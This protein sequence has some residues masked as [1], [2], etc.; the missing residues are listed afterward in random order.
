MRFL[1]LFAGIGGLDLGLERAGMTCAA[2]VEIDPFCRRVLA[3]HWPTVPRFPDVRTFT[4]DQI[5][6]QIDLIVGG[7]PCQDISAA[8]HAGRGIDGSKSG[9]WAEFA[10]L[11]RDFRPNFV[12]VENVANL[13]K[14]GL[15]RVLGDL[16]ACGYDAEWDVL[17]ACEFGADI[18]RKRL[19]II[20]QP[21]Q[22]RRAWVLC[23]QSGIGVEPHPAWGPPDSLD[24]PDDRA[25]RIEAWLRQPAVLRSLDGIPSK[26]VE[27]QLGGYGNAVVPQIAEWIGRAI[28]RHAN[29]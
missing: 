26:L 15:K 10:R 9:L 20:A 29:A 13:C 25:K 4:K 23:N 7:F 28:M 11:I 24:T 18:L 21:K 12:F 2:Q 19:F 17:P 22:M 16:A 1:S 8:N 14:R 6:G 27:C 5:N 3:K